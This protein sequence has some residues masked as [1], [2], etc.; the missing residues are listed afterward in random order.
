MPLQNVVESLGGNGL[1]NDSSTIQ[2]AL[3]TETGTSRFMTYFL[4]LPDLRFFGHH[5]VHPE[6]QV[7]GQEFQADVELK[8]PLPADPDSPECT[9][10][11]VEV[12]RLVE[13][14]VEQE[15]FMLIEALAAEIV[16]RIGDRFAPPLVTVRV[17][18]PHPPIAG[19]LGSVEVEISK[20]FA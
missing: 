15:R 5:G 9:L 11:Y 14:T 16:R 18:K 4:R 2:N 3:E 7:L 12:F 20:S 1:V 10:D 13:E 17:R 19:Q 8:L 6:E